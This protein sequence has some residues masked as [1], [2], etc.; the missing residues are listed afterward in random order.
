MNSTILKPVFVP[1]VLFISILVIFTFINP[2]LANEIFISTKNFISQKFAWL[3]MLS[4]AIFTFFAFFL[5]LSKFG[6][7]KL[8]PDQSK[9]SFSNFSWF[10]M[11]FSTGMGIGIVFWGIAEPV[12][13]YT[14][15]PIGAKE[16]IE[17]ARNAMNIVFFHWGLNA[18][19]IYAI[20]G[21]VLAYFSFRH[22]LPL[23]IRSALY[24]LI[25]D[26]IYGKIGHT[27][28]TI[29]VLGTIFGIA[30]SLGLGV[31]Q[32]NSGLNYVFDIDISLVN[33]IILIVLICA[34]A[35][36]SVVL[37]LDSGIKRLSILNLFLAF[38]LLVFV[39]I[40][41][42]SFYILDSFVQNIGVYLS[43]IVKQ[44]FNMYSYEGKSS[45]LSSW[46]L[47]Y[48]AWWISWAPFVGMFIARVSRGRTIRE[49]IIGVLFVPV[50][51]TFIWMT[52]FGNSALYLIIN[53]GY[54][55]LSQA[56]SNDV[57]IA[58]F[59]FLEFFPFSSVTSILVVILVAIFF[60]TSS[61]SGSLVVDTIASGGNSN[62]PV[63]QRAFWASSQGIV[64]IAMLIAGGF[65]ALQ[66]ASIIIGLP[67]AIILLI[68][69]WG[70]YKAL[71]LEYI[72]SESLQHHMNAGR[73]GEI[74]GTWQNRL[75]RIIEFP[76]PD[77]TRKFIDKEIIEAMNIVKKELEK[78][79]WIVEVTNNEKKSISTLRVEHSGDFDFI[80][81]VRLRSYDTPP[82]AYPE[83]INP[84]KEQ[85]KYAR[86]EV[87]LQD[88]NKAY[89]IYGYDIEVIVNDIIDQF[90]KHRHFLN[91][92]SSLNPVVP[93]D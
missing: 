72:R 86:A 57:S 16:S 37:G 84:Q 78:Y 23:S 50:G 61:D 66:S 40:V 81:E 89:D 85:K 65:E 49:F 93:V 91:N 31:L 21:L 74:C 38:A 90:E 30:T 63:W 62:N 4:I 19:A 70:I 75:N 60:I 9:P 87:F 11:L 83:N 28:D 46:T 55:A 15:P 2:S 5:A 47:F 42:P 68:S 8:G 29:A 56:I 53:E 14:N 76:K 79:A 35:M 22:G 24:P 67:F 48:W 39:I 13:H 59:K 71:N 27:V 33:Q 20:V 45:W 44:T 77:E 36:V 1:S 17:S 52:V 3:Y 26:K 34:I 80:Y 82:Y 58:I 25:G 54:T 92:T 10:A 73:H 43:N 18:W 51:F 32:I 88:G 6:K 12:V 64:A 7:F 69:C 41:G